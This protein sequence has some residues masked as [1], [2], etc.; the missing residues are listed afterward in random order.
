MAT[1]KHTRE[2]C[3]PTAA[4]G[5]AQSGAAIGRRDYQRALSELDRAIGTWERDGE[6]VGR[7]RREWTRIAL[8]VSRY[9]GPTLRVHNYGR[10]VI[11]LFCAAARFNE[12]SGLLRLVRDAA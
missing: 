2:S 4:A 11:D 1:F 6:P 9:P 3:N 5:V 8:A 7:L 12:R 10:E